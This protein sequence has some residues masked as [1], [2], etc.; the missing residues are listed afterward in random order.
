[1]GRSACCGSFTVLMVFLGDKSIGKSYTLN[2]F[3]DASFVGSAVRCTEGVWLSVTPTQDALV[4][5]LVFDGDD[6]HTC[7][8]VGMCS[9]IP[10]RGKLR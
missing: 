3:V 9:D 6:I 10:H 5:S 4:V 8:R 7:E 1:M 2:H